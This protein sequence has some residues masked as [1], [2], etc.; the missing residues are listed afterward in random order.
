M[1][2]ALA[3]LLFGCV[4]A[5]DPAPY[6]QV[7]VGDFCR[8][9]SEVLCEAYDSCC[10]MPTMTFDCVGTYRTPC[11]QELQPIFEDPRTGYDR[12]IASEVLAEARDYIR[13]RNGHPACDL[14]LADWYAD[15]AGFSRFLTGTVPAGGDCSPADWTDGAAFLSC[16]GVAQACIAELI[17]MEGVCE[18]KHREGE[19]CLTY[20]DCRDGLGCS[21]GQCRARA[22]VGQPC[23]TETDCESLVCDRP[24]TLPGR[25][26]VRT[27]AIFCLFQTSMDMPGP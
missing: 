8:E 15:R 19:P 22:A 1:R 27:P 24:T 4:V 20:L 18:P 5:N 3:S 21:G 17:T 9:L 23:L 10:N 26:A 2:Y 25:C 16:E 6:Q 11:E 14:E 12:E 7:H 13:G